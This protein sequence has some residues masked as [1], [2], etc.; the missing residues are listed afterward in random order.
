MTS[1]ETI[2][3]LG[4]LERRLA[5]EL[6]ELR[7]QDARRAALGAEQRHGLEQRD[8]VLGGRLVVVAAG[9]LRVDDRL[10]AA[11]EVQPAVRRPRRRP[12]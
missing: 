12:P 1:S 7:R 11:D 9:E 3:D 6:E 8:R 2:D 10:P 5:L 4:G